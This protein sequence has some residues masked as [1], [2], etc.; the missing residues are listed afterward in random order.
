MNRIDLHVSIIFPQISTRT[1]IS[2]C[3]ITISLSG[4]P[5]VMGTWG[6]YPRLDQHVLAAPLW[7]R[8]TGE[9][10]ELVEYVCID[11]RL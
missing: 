8:R 11:I 1:K 3:L 2:P 7:Q 5:A 4:H 9:E 6:T 10:K